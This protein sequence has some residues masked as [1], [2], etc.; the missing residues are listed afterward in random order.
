L[1]TEKTTGNTILASTAAAADWFRPMKSRA[2]AA[3]EGKPPRT[4][5]AVPLRS[6]MT[7]TVTTQMLPTANARIRRI[8]SIVVSTGL[9]TVL[10]LFKEKAFLAQPYWILLEVL[11]LKH[12]NNTYNAYRV[13]TK[14]T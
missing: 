11:S 5:H 14:Y 12:K 7:V 4:P 6:V 8:S 3:V 13:A 1:L 2:K 10:V 9:F